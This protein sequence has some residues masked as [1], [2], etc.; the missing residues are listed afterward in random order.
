MVEDE[1]N[2]QHGRPVMVQAGNEVHGPQFTSIIGLAIVDAIGTGAG[3]AVMRSLGI[4]PD[5]GQG[6]VCWTGDLVVRLRG[7]RRFSGSL[8]PALVVPEVDEACPCR[9]GG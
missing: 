5:T 9:A 4:F 3:M 8:R 1:R 6:N 2:P 7:I